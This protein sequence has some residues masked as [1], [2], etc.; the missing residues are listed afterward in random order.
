MN[1]IVPLR[2]RR[3][4]ACLLVAATAFAVHAAPA[5][6]DFGDRVL[7]KGSRGKDVRVL[8]S[9]LT[10]LGHATTVDGIFG[11]ATRRSVRRYERAEDLRVDGRVSRP[12]A[13]GMRIRLERRATAPEP[14]AAP[15]G[16]ATLSADGR[17][18]V[19]PADAPRRVQRAVAAAN[20]I[21]RKPYH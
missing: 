6:A 15:T 16:K 9:T 7:R 11:P 5:A 14:A 3:T 10:R 8:Q 17:T 4:P 13:R 2:H 18:A 20:R 12:Q 21:T 1:R 19:A